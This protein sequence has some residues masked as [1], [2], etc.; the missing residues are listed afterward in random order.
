MLWLIQKLTQADQN[1]IP[2][3]FETMH[4]PLLFAGYWALVFTSINLLPIGQLDGGHVLYGLV[5]AK[6][7]GILARI[8]FII[9]LLYGGMNAPT[10]LIPGSESFNTDLANN[11][12]YLGV[13]VVALVKPMN[14]LLNSVIWALSLFTFQYAQQMCGLN[15]PGYTGWLAFGLLLGRFLGVH[16]PPAIYEEGLNP[17]RKAVGILALILFVLCFVPKPLEEYSP[18]DIRQ[19]MKYKTL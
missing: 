13:L 2:H 11:A 15:L 16:H 17:L 19:T 1:L 12:F 7:H 4:Y 3:H 6:Q 5:G 10:I 9:F 14:G 8:F 18:S